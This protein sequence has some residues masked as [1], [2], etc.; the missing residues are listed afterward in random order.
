[1]FYKYLY[2]LFICWNV[3][4]RLN[5]SQPKLYIHQ[6]TSYR[7]KIYV[8]RVDFFFAIVLLE[9]YMNH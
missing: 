8:I 1:M 7:C 9:T 2:Y 6:L 5:H 3:G 4:L